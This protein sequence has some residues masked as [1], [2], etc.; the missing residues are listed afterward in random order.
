MFVRWV[1]SHLMPPLKCTPKIWARRFS[2]SNI[3]VAVVQLSLPPHVSPSTA[4]ENTSHH[5]PL[6]SCRQEEHPRPLA[7]PMCTRVFGTSSF[8]KSFLTSRAFGQAVRRLSAFLFP[9]FFQ[10]QFSMSRSITLQVFVLLSW[11]ALCV[12]SVNRRQGF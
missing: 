4:K 11:L 1:A 12:T 3:F 6:V 8:P 10:F 5:L 9:F 2:S 7:P